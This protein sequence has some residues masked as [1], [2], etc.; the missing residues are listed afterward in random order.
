MGPTRYVVTRMR[1]QARHPY[2]YGQGCL[3]VVREKGRVFAC[4][5]DG[6]ELH[7][8]PC[9]TGVAVI[10]GIVVFTCILVF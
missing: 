9:Q 3:V 1:N 6:H 7:P 2:E 5:P 4:Q 8:L 10:I